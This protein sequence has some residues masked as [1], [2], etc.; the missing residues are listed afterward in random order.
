M[1]LDCSICKPGFYDLSADNPDG[2]QPCDCNTLGTFEASMTCNIDSGQCICKTNVEGLKCDRCR[3]GTTGLTAINPL[4]CVACSCNPT[5]S[6][7]NNCD[8]I[9]GTCTCKLG[10]GGDLCDHCLP[11]FMGFSETGCQ[12]CQCSLDGAI[13]EVCNNVTGECTC[14]E[15]VIGANCD[16]CAE[17]FYNISGGCVPCECVSAGTVN[18]TDVCDPLLGLCDCKSNVEGRTCSACL[19]R[20]TNL[21]ASNPDGC[22]ECDCLD[23]NTDTSGIVCDPVTSQCE[24]LP[25][26]TGLRCDSCRDGFYFVPSS[27]CVPCDCQPEGTI[28]G[29]T[30]D[31]ISGQ[32][33][34]TSEGVGGRQCE[35]CLT[36]FF[37]YPR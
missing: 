25:T 2:C 15:N 19:T 27:G 1:G 31:P 3:N 21:T 35:E 6:V 11:G 9:D 26:A 14:R 10:V 20:F 4:G 13:S 30:C 24:C 16:S 8:P 34:C 23:I 37:Q 32:C 29:T 28:N 5:G 17:G 22:T 12:P 7:S 18:G 33:V 36:G